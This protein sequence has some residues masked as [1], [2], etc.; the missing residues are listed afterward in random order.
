MIIIL[1][2]L[3]LYFYYGTTSSS[4]TDNPYDVTVRRFS[5]RNVDSQPV[6][7]RFKI[8]VG[9]WGIARLTGTDP[10]KQR[11]DDASNKSWCVVWLMLRL[12]EVSLRV[13]L[14]II[15]FL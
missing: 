6:Q 2:I 4:T 3:C 11:P 7:Y 8:A 5:V 13:L 15:Y 14:S 1:H 9:L 10:G 12:L